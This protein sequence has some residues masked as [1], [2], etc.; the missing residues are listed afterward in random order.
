MPSLQPHVT[1]IEFV[2]GC[3]SVMIADSSAANR[4]ALRRA[5][6]AFSFP[7]RIHE[8][9]DTGEALAELA[10]NAHEIA[11]LGLDLGADRDMA[12]LK[13]ARE[14]GIGTFVV[15]TATATGE[16]DMARARALGAY[17][18]LGQPLAAADIHRVL[19][20]F[21]AIRTRRSALIVDDS[22][23]ARR[24]MTRVFE[25]SVFDIAVSEAADGIDGFEDYVRRPT[26][27][28]F[29]DLHMGRLDGFETARI[30]RAFKRDV[31]I[32]LV[33]ASDDVVDPAIFP[34]VLRKPFT[35][36]DLDAMLH[37]LFGLAA[38]F[39]VAGAVKEHA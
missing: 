20:S 1:D 7:T 14:G 6:E 12:A 11:F 4:H 19:D 22:G 27:V 36:L 3:W 30:F 29:L 2:E 31:K 9:A 24:L 17:D 8:I 10:T 5:V 26:D 18:V 15:A 39:S 38:P 37:R 32:V 13:R 33:T 34:L 21:A 16:A 23:V 28:V 35:A 25:R